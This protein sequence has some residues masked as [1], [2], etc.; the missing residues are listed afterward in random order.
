ML[1]SHA[2]LDYTA[3]RRQFGNSCSVCKVTS[4]NVVY[5][6]SAYYN[7]NQAPL[8]VGHTPHTVWK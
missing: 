3:T 5:K 2:S 8:Y 6:Y 4:Q 7:A 1:T